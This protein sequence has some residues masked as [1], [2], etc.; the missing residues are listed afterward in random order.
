VSSE[1]ALSREYQKGPTTLVSAVPTDSLLET[2]IDHCINFCV[3]D[4]TVGL[5]LWNSTELTVTIL[6]ATIPTLRPL[7]KQLLRLSLDSKDRRR[8]YRLGDRQPKSSAAQFTPYTSKASVAVGQKDTDARSNKR[9]LG[10]GGD[11][12]IVCT[13]VV[14]VEFEER[15]EPYTPSIWSSKRSCRNWEMI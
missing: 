9:I 13:D 8:S 10:H 15:S 5:I 1:P 6:C 7:Y 11:G 4:E 12:S 3:T 2:Y 14:Y